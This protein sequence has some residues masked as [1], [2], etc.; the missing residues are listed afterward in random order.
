MNAVLMSRSYKNN[1]Q[2]AGLIEVLIAVLI[3]GV[4][5]LGIAGLQTVAL[6]SATQAGFRSN[7]T[8]FA[9]S[10]ADR[11][12][13]NQGAYKEYGNYANTAVTPKASGSNGSSTGNNSVNGSNSST[14]SGKSK[15]ANKNK[16]IYPVKNVKDCTSDVVA[17]EDLSEI[18]A[19]VSN[20]LPGGTLNVSCDDYTGTPVCGDNPIFHI[21]ISWKGQYESD[22]AVQAA[23]DLEEENKIVMSFNPGT[24]E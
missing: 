6:K 24:S 10:L 1:Q 13:G 2:G 12:R 15:S 3:I 8:D 18:N 4:G 9:S 7:A 20:N 17:K 21:T 19:L 16:C 11:I 14:N 5:L 23:K 22:N